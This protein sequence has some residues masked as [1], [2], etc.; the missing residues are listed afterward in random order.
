MSEIVQLT[1]KQK[2]LVEK[3]GVYHEKSGLPPAPA[4]ILALLLVSPITEL[5]F[6][7]IRETLNL[8]KSATSN[9]INMLLNVNRLDYITK[10]GDRKRYFKNKVSNWRSELR[11]SIFKITEAADILEEI[12]EVRPNNTPEFNENL[13][14]IIDFLRFINDELPGLY[15]KWENKRT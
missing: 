15:Q 11:D 14:S 5:T 7:Q 12:L 6:D 10:S 9:A 2:E 8:S 1:A 3:I 13:S 4:R